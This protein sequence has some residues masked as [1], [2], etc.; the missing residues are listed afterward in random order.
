MTRAAQA[1]AGDEPRL[2]PARYRNLDARFSVQ[3]ASAGV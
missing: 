3:S 2:E 1:S